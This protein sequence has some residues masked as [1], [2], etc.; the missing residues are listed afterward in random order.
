MTVSKIKL[1]AFISMKLEEMRKG[2][3][4]ILSRDQESLMLKDLVNIYMVVELDK[5]S[6][7]TK[8]VN[9][10]DGTICQF[11]NST[12]VLK[13]DVTIEVEIVNPNDLPY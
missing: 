1:P 11:N 6:K 12:R 2:G 10:I 7:M 5:N 9:L 13:A 3:T 4:F 8:C